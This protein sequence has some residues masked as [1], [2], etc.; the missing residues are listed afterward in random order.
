M[1]ST[2]T[3]KTLKLDAETGEEVEVQEVMEVEVETYIEES[4]DGH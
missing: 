2:R 4:P 3:V 1:K